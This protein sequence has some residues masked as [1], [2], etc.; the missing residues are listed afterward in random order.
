MKEKKSF[1]ISTDF[2]KDKRIKAIDKPEKDK[3]IGFWLVLVGLSAKYGEKEN[4]KNCLN[5]KNLPA[6]IADESPEFI[7]SAL[8]ILEKSD[9]LNIESIS[10]IIKFE[11]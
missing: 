10:N 3:I 5:K 2:Y 4:L 11:D 6:F 8:K 9:L 7:N 1:Y